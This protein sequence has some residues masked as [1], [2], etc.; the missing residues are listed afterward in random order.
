MQPE[1]AQVENKRQTRKQRVVLWNHDLTR[2]QIVP[3]IVWRWQEQNDLCIE[4]RF[5]MS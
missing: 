3:Q 5:I 1:A 4:S 2:S